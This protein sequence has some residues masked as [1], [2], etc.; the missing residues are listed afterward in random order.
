MNALDYIVNNY[1]PEPVKEKP[2]EK[3]VER[4][5]SDLNNSSWSSWGNSLANSEVNSNSIYK[6]EEFNRLSKDLIVR[7]F[8]FLPPSDLRKVIHSDLQ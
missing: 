6:F 8:S 2:K 5:I 7:T 1:A 3:T 4:T